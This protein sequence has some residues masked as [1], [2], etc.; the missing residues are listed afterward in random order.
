[1]DT[2][3]DPS[4]CAVLHACAA[5]ADVAGKLQP[6]QIG[7]IHQRQWL[8]MLAPRALGGLEWP[9]PKVVRLEEALAQLDGSCGWVVTLCAGAGWFAG[10]WPEALGQRILKT[11]DLCLAGS[12]APTGFAERDGDG[13]RL[14]GRWLHASGAQIATHYTLNAQLREGSQPLLDA[15]GQPR[16]CAFVVPASQV[17]T[18]ADSWHSI[19]LRATTSRAFALHGVRATAEQAFVIDAAHACAQGP[20]YRF[21]FMALAFVTLGACVLGMAQHFAALARP[22][23]ER[24]IAQLGGPSAAAQALWSS[25]Q[26]ALEAARSVFYAALEQ[27]WQ[28]VQ[29]GQSLPSEQEQGLVNATLTLVRLA[30]ER[31]DGLYPWCGLLA[32]DPRT[33][34]N[35]VWRDF[36]TASQHTLWLR[37]ANPPA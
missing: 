33:K 2:P 6:E 29:Q 16:I 27:A 8:R 4:A 5:R 28:V 15:Q 22:L 10:F 24:P 3:V 26:H 37:Q 18:E 19:G 32:A 11:A 13:W 1:M 17:Q 31:V 21:P 36:H 35:R 9:L 23:T 25:G 34:I 20:L 12:G 14:T 30:R 7:L